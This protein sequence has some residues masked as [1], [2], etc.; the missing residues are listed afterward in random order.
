MVPF[1]GL[2]LYCSV[3]IP[4]ADNIG[5]LIPYIDLHVM[6]TVSRVRVRVRLNG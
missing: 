5:C 3:F 1:V 6:V 4:A 2:L